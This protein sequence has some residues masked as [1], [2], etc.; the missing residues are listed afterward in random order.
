[1]ADEALAVATASVGEFVNDINPGK[2]ETLYYV[3]D[4]FVSLSNRNRISSE[5]DQFK[6][7]LGERE[8]CQARALQDD[9]T[10][11]AAFDIL[12]FIVYFLISIFGIGN[13]AAFIAEKIYPTSTLETKLHK[14][15]GHKLSG[16]H[17]LIAGFAAYGIIDVLLTLFYSSFP[18][19]GSLLLVIGVAIGWWLNRKKFTEQI[20]TRLRTLTIGARFPRS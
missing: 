20:W 8:Y 16:I 10:N 3:S 6:S 5:Y 1:V 15:L 4:N 7:L 14:V 9:I 19:G 12:A 11:L 18:L 17:G 2:V 13:V